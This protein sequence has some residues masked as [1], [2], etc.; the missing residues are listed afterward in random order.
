MRR[1]VKNALKG[2][3]G[4]IVVGA[5]AMGGYAFAQTSAFDASMSKVYDIP[6]P[7]CVRSTDPD[8]IARGKHLAQSVAPCA[9]RDCHGTDLGGGRPIETGPI[10]T[11]TGPNLTRSLAEYSDGEIA[12]MM[13]HGLK[14]DGR[15]LA[16][17][18]V[19]DFAWLPDD[20]VTAVVSYLRTVPVVD[21]PDGPMEIRT[22]G[23]V[24]DRKGQ[25]IMDVARH[26]DHSS[27]VRAKGATPTVEYG[28][29]LAMGCSGCHG[30]HY[31]GGRI[32]GAPSSIPIPLNLTAHQ[33]GLKDWTID[34][35]NRLLDT[36]V[37]KNGKKIDPFMPYE[38]F[39]QFDDVERKALWAYL[40]S[41][42][43]LPFGQR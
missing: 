10:G 34:D 6:V 25:M 5:V 40:R 2:L 27:G 41:I 29:F 31:S 35:M 3:G 24:L 22:L 16:F 9:T 37:R 33:T 18:P 14:K 42:P 30:E 36:G 32:P 19:Q 12:R 4:L 43:S 13:R 21:R 17:M 7:S 23:K 28:Q 1:W 26:I 38:A 20:D 15:S 8:V 11:M 39:A